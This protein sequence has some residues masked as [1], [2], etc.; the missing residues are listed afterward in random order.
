[1]DICEYVVHYGTK[2]TSLLLRE[3]ASRADVSP[4]HYEIIDK[5]ATELENTFESMRKDGE[6]SCQ[7]K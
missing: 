7:F 4:E 3:M 5:I 1:M 6:C 2:S